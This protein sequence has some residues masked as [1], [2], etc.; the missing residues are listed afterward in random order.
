M[1]EHT[2]TIEQ[3]LQEARDQ[4]RREPVKSLLHLVLP[5]L[6]VI[7]IYVFLWW[8]GKAGMFT[9]FGITALPLGKFVILSGAHPDIPLGPWQLA[10]MVFLMDTWVGYVIAYNLHYIHRIP[11]VGPWLNN[12]QNY[13]RFWLSEH[14]W[15]RRWAITGVVLFVTFPLSGTGAPGGALLGRIV[16]LRRRVTLLAV[17]AGSA[18]G[19]GVM[20][21]FAGPLGG[22]LLGIKDAW[23]FHALGVGVLAI[24][25]IALYVLGVRVTRAAERYARREAAGG[26]A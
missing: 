22:V 26:E 3:I 12:V 9:V 5:I 16:G 23:W 21:A 8:I 25:L 15:V 24:L 11:K 18:I 1:N 13:C 19:C 7:G 14:R 2:S 6:V 20:A 4:E 10:L 17:M